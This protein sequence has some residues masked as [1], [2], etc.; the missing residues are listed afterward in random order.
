MEPTPCIE[1]QSLTDHEGRLWREFQKHPNSCLD[2]PQTELESA[3]Q[4]EQ[5]IADKWKWHPP[6]RHFLPL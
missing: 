2:P 4:N 5:N 1:A 6:A 3:C